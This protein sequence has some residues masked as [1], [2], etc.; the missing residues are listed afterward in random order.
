MYAV[1]AGDVFAQAQPALKEL[2]AEGVNVAV[3]LSGR[4]L[5]KQFKSANKKGIQFALVIG[6]NELNSGQ[7]SLKNLKTGEESTHSITRIATM[8]QD[9]RNEEL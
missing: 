4:A 9:H 8:I 2:R 5:D 7:F 3:D 1:L 6:E